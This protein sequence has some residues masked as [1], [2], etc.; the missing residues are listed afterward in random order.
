MTVLD[1]AAESRIGEALNAYYGKL[2]KDE[3]PRQAAEAIIAL[4]GAPE[5]APER[6]TNPAEP[7]AL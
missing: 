5:P 2:L 6:Q 7:A 1:E 4:Y 3:S